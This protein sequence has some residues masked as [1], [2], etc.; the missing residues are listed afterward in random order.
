MTL[1]D[2]TEELAQ[3]MAD[4]AL[5]NSDQNSVLDIIEPVLQKLPAKVTE[6][7]QQQIVVLLQDYDSIFSREAFDMGRTNLVEHSID[8]GS[9]RPIRQ[10]LRRHPRAHLDEIDQQVDELLQNG[11]VEPA[12]S[13]WASNVVLVKKKDGSFHLCVDYRRLNSVT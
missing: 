8:T 1:V 4:S 12:A 2:G 11:F 7:Q 13:P 10:A 5:I 6:E 3:N 9:H